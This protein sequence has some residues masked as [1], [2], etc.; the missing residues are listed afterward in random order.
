VSERGLASAD[1]V[2]D[3]TQPAEFSAALIKKA[4]AD[5]GVT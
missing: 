2:I 1:L 5:R 3:G 4:L